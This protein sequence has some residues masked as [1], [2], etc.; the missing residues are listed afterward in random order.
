VGFA[1][2]CV[3]KKLYARQAEVFAAFAAYTDSETIPA[4]GA[5][6]MIVTLGGRFG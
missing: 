6:G 4:G 3:Q 5:E 1:F 2:I